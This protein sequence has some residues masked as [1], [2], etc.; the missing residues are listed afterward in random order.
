MKFIDNIA[1]LVGQF[2]PKATLKY[3]LMDQTVVYKSN[4]VG[5]NGGAVYP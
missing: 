2:I 4:R 5:E 1:R 3:P